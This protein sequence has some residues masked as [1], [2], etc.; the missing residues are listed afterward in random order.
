MST[1]EEEI[2]AFLLPLAIEL[3]VLAAI[4]AVSDLAAPD[5]LATTKPLRIREGE[6]YDLP[7]R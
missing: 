7:L 4:N 5:E 6:W 1:L 3:A 2:I